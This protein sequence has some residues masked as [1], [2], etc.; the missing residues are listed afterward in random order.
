MARAFWKGAISFGMVVIP[1]RMYTATQSKS[2]SF[3]LL[4][5]KCFTRP[6][7]VYLCP[8]D[9]EY[10]STKD[11]VRGYEYTKGQYVTLTESD[12]E[13][14]PLKTAHAVNIVNFVEASEIDPIY[15]RDSYYLQPEEL[16]V[17]PY[18]LLIDVLEK[19]RRLGLAKVVLQRREHLCC[20]RP[21]DDILVLHT[22]YY[23]NEVVPRGE[24]APP[25]EV[26]SPEETDMAQT[27]VAATARPFN[28]DDYKDEYREALQTIIEAR[29]K[30]EEVKA[31]RPPKAEV[32]DLMSALRAS[33]QTAK[34]ESEAREKKREQREPVE[35]ER[36]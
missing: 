27:L 25:K 12:F 8:V 14:V 32:T 26:V 6:K 7:Q 30:G 36:R 16:G 23:S 4:H 15:Y 22:M 5:K 33:I 29:I 28:A 19:T 1:V 13:K 10:I 24:L 9:E 34:K 11:M 20:L 35:A 18:R 17:K 2:L 21:L 3:H 31:P